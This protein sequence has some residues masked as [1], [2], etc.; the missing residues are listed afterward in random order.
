MSETTGAK[1]ARLRLELKQARLDLQTAEAELAEQ[2]ADVE[3]FEYL[4]EAHVGHLVDRL[5]Q[6][7]AEV[8]E[9][10]RRI[11]RMRHDRLFEDSYRPV[12]EQFNSTW[13]SSPASKGDAPKR[14]QAPKATQAEIKRLYRQLARRYHPDLARDAAENAFRTEKMRAVNDAYRAGSMVELMALADELEGYVGQTAVINASSQ[15]EA[16]MLQ[17]LQEELS[18]MQKRLRH[19]ENEITNLPNR[20][21]VALMV[22]VKFGKKEGRDVLA[23]MALTLEQKIAKKTVERDLLKSQFDHL[24]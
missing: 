15:T 9:Y 14:S 6:L 17:A 23:E 4:F 5:A 1:I 3:A 11:K 24:P 19:V 10:M 8:A 22:E 16:Q 20:P 7:E 12:E 2:L 21:I 13:H 18:R